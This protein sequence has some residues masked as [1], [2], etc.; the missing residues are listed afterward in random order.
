MAPI[1][2]AGAVRLRPSKGRHPFFSHLFP[3][4]V[5]EYDACDENSECGRDPE[6]AFLHCNA[7]GAARS[8]SRQP[9]DWDPAQVLSPDQALKAYRLVHL[10]GK[11]LDRHN[12]TWMVD[13]G[14]LLG[15]V[16]NQGIILHDD[17]V[18]FRFWDAT[19]VTKALKRKVPVRIEALRNDLDKNNLK[20]WCLPSHCVMQFKDTVRRSYPWVDLMMFGFDEK[21]QNYQAR[22]SK[23]YTPM[24]KDL[25]VRTDGRRVD[26]DMLPSK[27][28]PEDESDAAARAECPGLM[29]WKFGDT[30][31]WGMRPELVDDYLKS[32]YGDDWQTDVHCNSGIKPAEQR[33]I[34]CNHAGIHP[35]NTTR[36]LDEHAMPT[37]PLVELAD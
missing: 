14:T 34:H 12:I 22:Q 7:P 9:H 8:L 3:A 2:M 18:D 1:A 24:P 36:S 15:A 30:S 29:R 33:G 20:V 27:P 11:L 31:V 25:C 37:G 26:L 5:F 23:T 19:P 4:H 16:R 6:C 35:R 13:L 32:N 10:G 28:L 21:K 17:D